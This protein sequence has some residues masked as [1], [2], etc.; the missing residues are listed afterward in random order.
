MAQGTIFGVDIA[1]N[2]VCVHGIATQ[3]HVIVKK[4]LAGRS[5]PG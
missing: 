4:R 2:A 1:E 3:S 5:R